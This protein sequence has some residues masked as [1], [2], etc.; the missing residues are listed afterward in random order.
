MDDDKG[1]LVR[2]RDRARLG[3]VDL[4]PPGMQ[5]GSLMDEFFWTYRRQFVSG[6]ST[7]TR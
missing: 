1:V 7:M 4:T 2:G 6:E 3:V 5:L